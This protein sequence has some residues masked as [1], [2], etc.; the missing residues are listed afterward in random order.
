MK[1]AIRFAMVQGALGLGVAFGVGLGWHLA[2]P[3]AEPAGIAQNAVATWGVPSRGSPVVD[4]DLADWEGFG[5]PVIVRTPSGAQAEIRV[6]VDGGGL[7]VA[8]EV[9]DDVIDAGP[10]PIT[11]D[12][13]DVVVRADG[14]IWSE[15]TFRIK[16]G[17][18][19]V[20]WEDGPLLG[21]CCASEGVQW[22]TATGWAFEVRIPARELPAGRRPV[23][24]ASLA[25]DLFDED[26]GVPK[27]MARADLEAGHLPPVRE[28]LDVVPSAL[29]G[30]AAFTPG[31][32]SPIVVRDGEAVRQPVP[33]R[34]AGDGGVSLWEGA[35][36]A[37]TGV[38]AVVG[39]AGVSWVERRGY[40][41]ARVGPIDGRLRLVF[42]RFAP[43]DRHR[44]RIV[45]VNE[46]GSIVED[47]ELL[48][49]DDGD[50]STIPIDGTVE[51]NLQ[52]VSW[53]GGLAGDAGVRT[54]RTLGLIWDSEASVW[55]GL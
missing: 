5:T 50:P 15:R 9:H 47:R 55:K 24:L 10:S 8:G 51:I 7:V 53:T 25:V 26:G 40:A 31:D 20:A 54:R 33:V 1:T 18:V 29:T 43:G 19:S 3:E 36:C 35:P 52:R 39:D 46:N 49:T 37:E 41:L 13:V 22:P 2:S 11:G 30:C 16:P 4:G 21:A 17:G 42:Y 6:R 27:A 48:L 34:I 44:V 45:D 23:R 32:D 38:L 12:R 28:A 14:P